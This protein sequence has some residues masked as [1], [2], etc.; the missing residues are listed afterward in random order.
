MAQ[1]EQPL[2]I[3]QGP[4]TGSRI[5]TYRGYARALA[6]AALLLTGATAHGASIDWSLG[7]AYN[8]PNGFQG[9]L[10]NGSLVAAHNVGGTAPLTVDPSGIN[11]TFL[12]SGHASFDG[13]LF[14]SGSPGSSDVAWNNI[15]NST[16]FNYSDFTAP[17]FL[18]GLTSG[19]SYQ[20]QFFASDSRTCCSLR[21]STFSNGVGP[22]SPEVVVGAFTSVVG[23]FVADGTSQTIRFMSSS[24]N[25]SLSA[26][27]LRDVTQVSAI[28]EPSTYT[29][30]VLGLAVSVLGARGRRRI[31]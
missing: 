5:G 13:Y 22:A 15:V 23:S 21:T 4:G 6:W 25:P 3:A 2:K 28:P 17:G 7:P 30:A 11:I 26:Y 12:P 14:G 29:L 16:Y 24:D 19:R 18:T 9:I 1:T 10:T 8:G 20:V 27:V 31:R